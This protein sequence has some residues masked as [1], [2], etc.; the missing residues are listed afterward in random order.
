MRMRF[1][2]VTLKALANFSPGLALKPW[3]EKLIFIA[4]LK[5]LRTGFGIG[6]N[7]TQLLQ[8]CGLSR[9]LSFTQGCQSATLGWNWR[10]LSALDL[11]A[12][13]S[14]PIETMGS[15]NVSADVSGLTTARGNNRPITNEKKEVRN[16][17]EH[18]LKFSFARL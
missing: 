11:E 16:V 1:D 10:T 9:I 15:V 14:A 18:R 3:G 2:G 12:T 17:L 7:A 6:S 4:T 8:S 5:E 13:A